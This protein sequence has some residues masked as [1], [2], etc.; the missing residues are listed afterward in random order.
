MRHSLFRPVF[1]STLSTPLR[2]CSS[3]SSHVRPLS[4]TAP[5]RSTSPETPTSRLNPRI[6]SE[7]KSRIGKCISFG[8]NK[9]QTNEA[10]SMLE[11]MALDWRGMLVGSEG[12]LT[13]KDRIGLYRQEVVWGEMDAMCGHVNNVVYNRYAESARV[14][15]TRSFA[16]I[17]DPKHREEWRELMTPLSVGLILRSIRTDYKFPVTYPDRVS[18]LHKLHREPTPDADHFKLDVVILSETHRR[19]AA[20]CFEDIVVY[21]YRAAKK[22]PL[23]PFMIEQF[24]EVWR[25]QEEAKETYTKKV[26]SLIE[27]VRKLEKASWDRPDAKEDLGSAAKA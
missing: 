7:L 20:R 5:R 23:R 6:L 8:L 16:N 9:E 18:V 14:N 15:W 1:S 13:S 17:F 3:F 19:I 12:F 27:S 11:E 2:P 22:A 24:K 21:D 26:H 4:T 10:C 25:L